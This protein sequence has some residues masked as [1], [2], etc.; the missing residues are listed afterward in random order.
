MFLQK[1]ESAALAACQRLTEI[2]ACLDSRNWPWD[3]GLSLEIDAA[4]IE[5]EARDGDR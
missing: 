2:N 4:I 3:R 1:N 5:L